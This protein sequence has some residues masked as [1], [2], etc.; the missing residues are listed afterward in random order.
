[1]DL[2]SR[3]L[4]NYQPTPIEANYRGG[5][6]DVLLQPLLPFL[7]AATASDAVLDCAL[8]RRERQL[9]SESMSDLH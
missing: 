3:I 8:E 1:M 9:G 5:S 4:R 2:E 6:D 7:L